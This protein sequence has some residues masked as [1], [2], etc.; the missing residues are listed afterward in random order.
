MELLASTA[1][2][3]HVSGFLDHR[4][5]WDAFAPVPGDVWEPECSKDLFLHA[6]PP[7]LWGQVGWLT[8]L[9]LPCKSKG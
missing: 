8:T 6:K 1:P 2:F 3:H 9:S 5:L 4:G 7:L